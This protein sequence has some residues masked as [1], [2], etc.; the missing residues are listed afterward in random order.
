[1]SAEHALRFCEGGLQLANT[2]A[3]GI[4]ILPPGPVQVGANLKQYWEVEANWNNAAIAAVVP[5]SPNAVAVN[6]P[7]MAQQPRCMVEQISG[8]I[9]G[10]TESATDA[11]AN[12]NQKSRFR[13]T[14][15]GVGL[16]ANTVVQL[17]S[18]LLM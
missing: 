14:A 16:D 3:N 10:N 17:Q 4:T 11:I 15:R 13:I 5:V 1:Q 6:A 2:A 7:A 12:G 9:I 8:S 18:Y